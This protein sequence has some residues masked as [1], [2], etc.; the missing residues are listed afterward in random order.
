MRVAFN[1]TYI[2]KPDVPRAR[3]DCVVV[4]RHLDGCTLLL[5]RLYA[6]HGHTAMP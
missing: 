2:D 5:V 6:L 4:W 3:T 1:I